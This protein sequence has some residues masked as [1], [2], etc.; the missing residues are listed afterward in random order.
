MVADVLEDSQIV[1]QIRHGHDVTLDIL[2][3]G[4]DVFLLLFV[5]CLARFR[6]QIAVMEEF[7]V[8]SRPM[9]IRRPITMVAMWM[10]KSFQVW[11]AS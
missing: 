7:A 4:A 1:V 2:V 3:E 10:K 6:D 5:E 11:T 8:C 9:A